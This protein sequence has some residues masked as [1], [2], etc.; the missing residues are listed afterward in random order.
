LL[1]EWRLA[2]RRV[3]A[4]R[5][6]LEGFVPDLERM[7][8]AGAQ[9]SAVIV[10]A[11]DPSER[12]NAD[13]GRLRHELRTPLNAIKGYGELLARQPRIDDNPDFRGLVD[14]LRAELDRVGPAQADLCRTS[15]FGLSPS[16]SP[17]SE[18]PTQTDLTCTFSS[19]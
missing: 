5:Q 2:M 9:L 3:V 6:D 10:Q 7:R 19:A 18:R 1:S 11:I 15:S 17:S 8:T 14:F 13:P 16:N 12:I 4:L